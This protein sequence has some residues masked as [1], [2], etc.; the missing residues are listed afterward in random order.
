MG[1]GGLWWSNV[2]NSALPPKRL[3]PDTWPE[4]PALSA[5]WLRRKGR[6]EKKERKDK[7]K[8]NKV[9]KIKKIIKNKK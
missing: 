2:L 9:I 3:R 8:Q 1:L 7:I 4:H 6:L 5:T